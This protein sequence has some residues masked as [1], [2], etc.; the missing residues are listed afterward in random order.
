[1]KKRYIVGWDF[2]VGLRWRDGWMDVL[3]TLK[4]GLSR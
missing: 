4:T 1:M 2:E 3:P